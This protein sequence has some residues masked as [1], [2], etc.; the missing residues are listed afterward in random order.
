MH[1]Q[2]RKKSNVQNFV[3]VKSVSFTRFFLFRILK[4]FEPVVVD[5]LD[6]VLN[7]VKLSALQFLYSFPVV[8]N[9]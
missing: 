2:G 6:T 7:I 3:N 4:R 1:I 9:E 5:I 8:I